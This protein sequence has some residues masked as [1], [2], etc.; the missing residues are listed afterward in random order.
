MD[1]ATDSKIEI[2]C[3]MNVDDATWNSIF[4]TKETEDDNN[5]RQ[6]NKGSK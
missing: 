1:A 6:S 2:G 4:G 5:V 3:T